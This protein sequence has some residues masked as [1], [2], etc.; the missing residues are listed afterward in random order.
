MGAFLKNMKR[1]ALCCWG[2]AREIIQL[3]NHGKPDEASLWR[4]DG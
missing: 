3:K 4:I 2:T 1:V